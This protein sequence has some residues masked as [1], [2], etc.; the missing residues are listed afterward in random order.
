MLSSHL[1]ECNF[2]FTSPDKCNFALFISIWHSCWP[3]IAQIRPLSV[4]QFILCLGGGLQS[5]LSS[6]I[7]AILCFKVILFLFVTISLNIYE[8]KNLIKFFTCYI[9]WEQTQDRSILLNMPSAKVVNKSHQVPQSEKKP[10]QHQ[11]N[12]WLDSTKQVTAKTVSTI[13]H[14]INKIPRAWN[15]Q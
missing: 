9:K 4:L 1:H 6:S 10:K 11:T 14:H 2:L 7:F 5:K 3:L 13:I 15:Y 12:L 8:G